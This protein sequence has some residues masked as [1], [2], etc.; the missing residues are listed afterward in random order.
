MVPD[1]GSDVGRCD[2][3]DLNGQICCSCLGLARD[4]LSGGAQIELVH[5]LHSTPDERLRDR[6]L[7]PAQQ[8]DSLTGN[9]G[10]SLHDHSKPCG[11]Q[12]LP[13]RQ[14]LV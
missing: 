4:R 12:Q 1:R 2:Q 14:D 7:R 9:V 3:R 5:H 8:S 6:H 13:S 11:L 10:Y